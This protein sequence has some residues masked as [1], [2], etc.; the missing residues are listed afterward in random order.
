VL[1]RQL[2]PEAPAEGARVWYLSPRIV[3]MGVHVVAARARFEPHPRNPWRGRVVLERPD[4]VSIRFLEA[5]RALDGVDLRR[6]RGVGVGSMLLMGRGDEHV[7]AFS[8][9]WM[10]APWSWSP[11]TTDWEFAVARARPHD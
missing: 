10:G 2:R 11:P 8:Q 5:V 3:F 7:L 6:E 1:T 9:A 4:A